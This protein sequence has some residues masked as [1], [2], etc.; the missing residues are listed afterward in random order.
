MASKETEEKAK[1]VTIKSLKAWGENPLA[2]TLLA[3]LITAQHARPF[4]PLPM[5]VPPVLLFS[6]YLNLGD[7]KADAAGI[8]AAW[9]GLYFVLARRRHFPITTKFG[10]R[11][12]IRGATMALCAANLV[13]GG[14]AYTF[15]QRTKKE[16]PGV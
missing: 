6:S 5:L 13:A 16:E 12:I 11:G 14:I 10:T 9:S 1:G 15:G 4:H 2:P 3:T 7:Y 8:S